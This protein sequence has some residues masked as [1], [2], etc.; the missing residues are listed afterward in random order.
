M[1][2]MP[3]KVYFVSSHGGRWRYGKKGG[4]YSVR[5]H[6]E[7]RARNL[8]SAGYADSVQIFESQPLTWTE[9]S[10]ESEMDTQ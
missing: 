8:I 2:G 5:K 9:V 7:A 3:K 4:V 6:A 10:D 1:S